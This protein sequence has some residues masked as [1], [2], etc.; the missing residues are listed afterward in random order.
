[1]ERNTAT[2]LGQL[3]EGDRFRFPSSK[4]GAWQVT[5]VF[6]NQVLYNEI[7]ATGKQTFMYD[8]VGAASRQVVFLRHTKE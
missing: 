3:K 1:M 5:G 6:K 4:S 7:D 2:T 8:K